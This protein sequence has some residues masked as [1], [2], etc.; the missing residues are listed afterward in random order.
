MNMISR[1]WPLPISVTYYQKAASLPPEHPRNS[2]IPR[3]S[4]RPTSA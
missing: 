1:P 3:R 2:A 4:T